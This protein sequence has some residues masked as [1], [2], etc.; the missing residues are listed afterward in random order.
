LAAAHPDSTMDQMA[1]MDH[2]TPTAARPDAALDAQGAR[3]AGPVCPFANAC[4]PQVIAVIP[5]L[6][7]RP[8][9]D[10]IRSTRPANAGTLPE[11]DLRAPPTPPPNL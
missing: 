8:T 6:P 7:A 1:G 5:S 10:A 2:G 9:P 11:F 4:A 3:T